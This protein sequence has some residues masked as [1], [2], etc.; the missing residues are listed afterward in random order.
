MSIICL[1]GAL[2]VGKTSTANAL[3]ERAGAFIVPE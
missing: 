2:A 1:E 3:S